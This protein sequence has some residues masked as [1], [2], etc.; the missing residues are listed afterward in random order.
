MP[1]QTSPT[2][3][4]LLLGAAGLSLLAQLGCSTTGTPAQAVSLLEP[5]D[6]ASLSSPFMVRFGIKG[7]AVAP[8]GDV[9]A[10]SGHHHLVINAGP[11]AAGVPVP[12][13]AQHLHFGR[14]Q[15]ETEVT[16]PPGQYTLTAQ[17]ANGAH[18]SYGPAMS[19]TIRVTV[20]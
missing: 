8:A 2:I 17:F 9:L 10:N 14:G 18:Q 16:L 1:L 15:T 20:K 12:F 4:R 3:R 5:L 13:N 7:M 11:V 19:Q 6:G